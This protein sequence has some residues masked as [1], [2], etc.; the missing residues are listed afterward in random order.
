MSSDYSQATTLRGLSGGLSSPK[1]EQLPVPMVLKALRLAF[2]V[3]GHMAPNTAGNFAYKLWFTPT[4]FKTPAREKAALTSAT[5][6]TH[7]ID[8]HDIVTFSWG[9]EDTEKPLALLVHG[10]SGRGTQLAS[11]VTPLLDAGYRVL[12]FDAPAHGKSSGKQTN[13]YEVADV[14]VALQKLYGDIEAVITHSFGGPCLTAAM[15]RG[16]IT[17][18]IVSICPP[19]TTK[20]LVEKFNNAL[21]VPK[22]AAG[23]MIL[24]IEDD[25][26]KDIWE[27]ISMVNLVKNINTPA[28]LIHDVNDSDIPWQEGEDVAKAWDNATFIKTSG[29]G[30]RR[31]LRDD[32]VIE[33]AIKHVVE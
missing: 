11:F 17:R 29:L 23:K 1:K 14:I 16:F 25:F 12:S 9:A 21:H 32:F 26:G 8:K 18:R 10:W 22:K 4:R 31:I 24:K 3:G 20:G 2:S 27:E 33:S 30:H 7:T 6:N 19:A 13:L 5:I 15:H 28:L